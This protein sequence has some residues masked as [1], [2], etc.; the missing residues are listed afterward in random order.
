MENIIVLLLLL[1][2]T[3]GPISFYSNFDGSVMA[4]VAGLVS[5]RGRCEEPRMSSARI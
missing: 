3:E 5:I 2:Y 4:N 1:L